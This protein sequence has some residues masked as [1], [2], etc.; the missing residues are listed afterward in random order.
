MARFIYGT[1]DISASTF[2]SWSNAITEGSGN[3]SQSIAFDDFYPSQGPADFGIQI[4]QGASVFYGNV[5][6]ETGGTVQVDAPYSVG[7]ST[8]TITVKNLDISAHSITLHARA[9]YPHSFDS[10]RTAAGG[11]GS[12]IAA[13]NTVTLTDATIADHENYYAHFTT[14]HGDP[15]N[16]LGNPAFSGSTLAAD[17]STACADTVD[18]L[19][20]FNGDEDNSQPVVGDTIGTNTDLSS[21]VSAGFIQITGNKF[22]QTNSSGIVTATGSCA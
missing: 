21:P 11:G 18:T 8:S 14:T 22:I 13:T 20:Y 15:G 16:I 17:S 4:L 9:N 7:A 5:I 6:P 10:W 12:Q 1:N 2:P 19:Y 3:I